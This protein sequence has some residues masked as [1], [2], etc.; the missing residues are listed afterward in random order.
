VP[1]P[2]SVPVVE[3][4]IEP[5]PVIQQEMPITT[6]TTEESQIESNSSEATNNVQSNEAQ[7]KNEISD[8]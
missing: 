5:E 1:E 8:F 3:Q 4:P 2:E 7:D 6:T